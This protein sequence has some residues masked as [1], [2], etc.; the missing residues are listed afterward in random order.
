MFGDEVTK[1]CWCSFS[2]NNNNVRRLLLLF[3]IYLFVVI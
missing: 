2:S 1:N 3:E